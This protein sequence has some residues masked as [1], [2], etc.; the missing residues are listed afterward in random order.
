MSKYLEF[1]T[2][3]TEPKTFV[4]GIFSKSHGNKLA[5][6]QWYPQWRQYSFFPKENTVWNN[7]CLQDI[8]NF[9][10]EEMNAKKM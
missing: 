6:V 3:D 10:Q 8:I 1:R 5:T 7:E 9:I 4:Y 2:I